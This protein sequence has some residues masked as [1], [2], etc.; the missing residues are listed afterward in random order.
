RD[1]GGRSV[2]PLVGQEAVV[3]RPTWL[4]AEAAHDGLYRAAVPGSGQR[5]AFKRVTFRPGGWL[6][7]AGIH[8]LGVRRLVA[9]AHANQAGELE[10][11]YGAPDGD[12]L[13]RAAPTTTEGWNQTEAIA[14]ELNESVNDLP[15]GDLYLVWKGEGGVVTDDMGHHRPGDVG[16]ID[17]LEV[18]GSSL[19]K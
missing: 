11:R 3:L 12:L 7:L 14:L 15:P 8:L 18:V 5:G 6:K 13:A 9:H 10:L 17:A 16:W 19:A 4:E 2:P 1:G